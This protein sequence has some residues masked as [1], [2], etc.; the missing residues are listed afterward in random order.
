M[1]LLSNATSPGAWEMLKGLDL[2]NNRTNRVT[3]KRAFY[4]LQHDP[5]RPIAEFLN[6]L[7]TLADQLK[8]LKVSLTD[9]D[10]ID[11]IIYALHDDWRDISS[12]LMKN[13]TRLELAG[14]M[15]T[16]V[17]EEKRR[18]KQRI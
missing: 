7:T 5:S 10:M 2:Q 11:V 6:N 1:R 14:V 13:E 16:L 18:L 12:V 17:N 4:T 15:N 3:L 9:D 8:A